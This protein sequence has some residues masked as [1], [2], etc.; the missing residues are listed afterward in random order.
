[1]VIDILN[2]FSFCATMYI[3]WFVLYSICKVAIRFCLKNSEISSL[4]KSVI[5][6]FSTLLIL[7]IALQTVVHIHLPW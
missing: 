5:V 2:V 4:I 7:I 6:H 1:M 3:L